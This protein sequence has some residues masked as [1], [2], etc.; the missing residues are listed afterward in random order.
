[1]SKSRLLT[2]MIACFR[3]TLVL[4]AIISGVQIH[5]GA[6]TAA[7][8]LWNI[9]T[10]ESKPDTVR[11]A[12]MKQFI[13][14]NYLFTNYDSAL[15]LAQMQYDFAKSKGLEKKLADPIQVMGAAYN[16]KG[17]HSKAIEHYERSLEMDKKFGNKPAMASSMLNLGGSILP[18]EIS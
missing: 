7:D 4:V 15:V 18:K 3:S 1:M 9:W 17:E 13:W 14:N 5:G 6:Q 8:S 12:A 16:Y 2:T 11:L 10:D